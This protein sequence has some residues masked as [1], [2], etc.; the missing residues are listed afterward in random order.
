M[1]CYQ[2]TGTI[3]IQNFGIGIDQMELTPCLVGPQINTTRVRIS[4]W[5]YLKGAS[6]ST[7]LHY[8]R[9]SFGPFSFLCDIKV[10]VKHQSSSSSSD[11]MSITY[12]YIDDIH[13]QQ[14]N[15]WHTSSICLFSSFSSVREEAN[16]QNTHTPGHIHVCWIS[17]FV[18]SGIGEY[19]SEPFSGWI[20]AAGVKIGLTEMRRYASPNPIFR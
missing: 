17:F 18:V 4:A 20:M 1:W 19:S 16:M 9:R 3:M 15:S 8:L 12:R 2:Y 11:K 6:S 5:A 10:A 13:R 7:S 14:H